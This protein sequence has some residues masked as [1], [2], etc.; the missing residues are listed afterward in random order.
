M[1]WAHSC[2]TVKDTLKYLILSGNRPYKLRAL[3]SFISLYN[4]S[5]VSFITSHCFFLSLH[6]WANSL[7]W[8]AQPLSICD[9]CGIAVGVISWQLSFSWLVNFTWMRSLADGISNLED[10]Q[11]HTHSSL[12]PA[13]GSQRGVHWVGSL[14]LGILGSLCGYTGQG[15][16]KAGGTRMFWQQK[17]VSM[18]CFCCLQPALST[19]RL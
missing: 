14:S 11:N 6:P 3:N 1:P 8:P 5:N 18:L 9:D 16:T 12:A 10:V 7:I 2:H 4:L 15:S 17:G 19:H 13:G